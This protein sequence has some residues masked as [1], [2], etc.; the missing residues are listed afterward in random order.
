[1]LVPAAVRW[2]RQEFS[3]PTIVARGVFLL[4]P[5]MPRASDARQGVSLNAAVC[6]L[7]GASQP[8]K[9]FYFVEHQLLRFSDTLRIKE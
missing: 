4:R 7:L 3:A 8:R 9:Y 2:R 6:N 5:I 1:M